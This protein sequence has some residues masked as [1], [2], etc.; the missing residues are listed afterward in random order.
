[1]YLKTEDRVG[2]CSDESTKFPRAY[3]GCQV[4][5]YMAR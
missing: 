1:M 5:S 4:A 3:I 2:D